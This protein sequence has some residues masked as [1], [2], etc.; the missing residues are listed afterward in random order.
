MCPFLCTCQFVQQSIDLF[1]QLLLMFMYLHIKTY[2]D[3]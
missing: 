1:K 3:I 2:G